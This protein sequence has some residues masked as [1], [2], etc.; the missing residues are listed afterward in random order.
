MT[1]QQL[2][3]LE[4][5]NS[6]TRYQPGPPGVDPNWHHDRE[7]ARSVIAI[8]GNDLMRICPQSR[9]LNHALNKL[10]EAIGWCHSAI[11]RHRANSPEEY[12]G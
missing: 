10:E 7:A 2:A 6:D 9:E 12:A 3:I 4:R 1:K 5:W 8:A 11:D